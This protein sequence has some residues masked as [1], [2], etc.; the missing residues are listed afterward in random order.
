MDLSVLRS[1]GDFLPNLKE[2]V[3]EAPINDKKKIYKGS[4]TCEEAILFLLNHNF[5]IYD[6][7]KNDKEGNEVNIFFK[8][9]N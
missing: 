7:Q 2:G 9:R 3:L 6:I 1:L 4:H 5:H 8:Q